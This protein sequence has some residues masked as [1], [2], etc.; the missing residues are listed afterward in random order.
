MDAT[1]ASDQKRT[2]PG[3][4]VPRLPAAGAHGIGR[5][6][7]VVVPVIVAGLVAVGAALVAFVTSDPTPA[8]LGGVAA[9]LVASSFAEAFPVPLEPAGYVSLTAVFI[10]G[11]A[12]TY[13]WAPAVLIAFLTGAAVELLQRK[14]FVR[15]AY[16]SCLYAVAGAASGLAVAAAPHRDAVE[17]LLLDVLVG[18]IAFYA[19][20]VFLATAV[21]A[22]WAGEPL[23]PLLGRNAVENAAPFAIMA[24]VSLMLAVLWQQSPLLMG[25]LIGPLVAVALYQRS[26]HNAMRAMRL[27]LT[28]AQTGLGNKRHF[29]ELLQRYLDRAEETGEPL[30]L[31]LI[32]LDDFKTINDTYGHP[33]GDRVLAQVAARLRRGGES[34]RLGGDEFA[35]LLPG[36][37]TEEGREVAEAVSRRITEAKY[38]HGGAVSISIGVASYPSEGVVRA[39]LVR[40]ADKALYSAKG[41]GKARVH[42]HRPDGNIATTPP[43]HGPVL[44]GRVAGLRAAASAAHAVI[45]RDVNIGT[46]SHNVGELAARIA[47][48]LGLDAEQVELVRVAGGLHDIG[49]LLV[50]ED[51]VH[52]PGPLTPAERSIVERHSEIGQRMLEALGLEPIAT[53][54]H[55]HH[56]RWDGE[57][58]PAGLA[59]EEIPLPSRI[60]FVADAFDTMTN[61]R[62]YRTKVTRAEALAEIEGCSGTQFD[63]AVVAA[64]REELGD[65]PLELVLPAS[66]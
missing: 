23:L 47:Q 4:D 45:E 19:V 16:N 54:V 42:V 24:S 50:P 22:R 29:E 46:H 61:D 31:C 44:A 52:K 62:V 1:A 48:R 33:A 43:A 41:H 34:F 2:P 38:D 8:M 27:A 53:W 51:I 35:I 26:V 64:L 25:A 15:I 12:V 56:E 28:D 5:V 14:P 13:G 32:D 17:I 40:V 65:T 7:P 36:R 9:L 39:E 60:L 37:T 55:H 57:G 20:N 49:K 10:V 18:A 30:T 59:G 21:I 3:G 63:P 66:A 6:V 58:Y 11:A